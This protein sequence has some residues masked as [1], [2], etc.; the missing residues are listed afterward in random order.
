MLCVAAKLV[1][2]A[3]LPLDASLHAW[4]WLA[5]SGIAGFL[6]GDLC[7]FRAY[8]VLGPRL[9]SLIMSLAPPLTVLF[10]GWILDE[11]LGEIALLGMSLT[12]AGVAWAI[13]DRRGSVRGLRP[14]RPLA[15]ILLAFGGAI[16]QAGGLVLSKLGM[17]QYH[18]LPATQIR[19]L[20][21]IVGFSA[22]FFLWRWWPRVGRGLCDGPA[23][24]A[25]ALGSVFGPFLGVT[26]SLAAVQATHAGV[27]ASIMATTPIIIIPMVWVAR[28]ERVGW[29]G[30][31]G[32]V[33]AVAGVALLFWQ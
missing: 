8:V 18:P 5:L 31:V 33:L 32:T 17:G 23:L 1:R 26:L 15:G 22:V 19:V 9:S 28:G 11:H 21:G 3:W 4:S 16:G 29:S 7:L 2:G 6:V 13:L 20:A 27:A 10:G 12:V 30:L 24:R 14:A 25:T